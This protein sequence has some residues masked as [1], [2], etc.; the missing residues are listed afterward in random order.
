VEETGKDLVMIVSNHSLFAITLLSS[1]A[2][3]CGQLA[4]ETVLGMQKS[5]VITSVKHYIGNE[6]E[7][8]RTPNDTSGVASV[9]SNIDDKTI[10]ELYLWPF[11][12]AVKAGAG[13]IMCSYNRL[14]NSYGCQNSKSLNGL[15]KT[16][17]G[18]E[19]FVV[20]DWGAQRKCMYF[21][22][23]ITGNVDIFRYW[24]ILCSGWDGSCNAKLRF[25]GSIRWQLD[26]CS[27]QWNSS[28]HEID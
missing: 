3:L 11:A 26:Y 22:T 4:S 17:L 1:V 8:N 9:S 14:N 25:L 21:A 10:H 12:D 7:T 18:F 6:Q 23:G 24:T 5:G 13:S 27:E 20:S 2:Y 28:R 19:G 15:L 16:E